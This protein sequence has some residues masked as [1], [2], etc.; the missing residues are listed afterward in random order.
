MTLPTLTKLLVSN[1][2]KF[3]LQE[4]QDIY[5]ISHEEKCGWYYCAKANHMVRPI[6][7]C[8]KT[9]SRAGIDLDNQYFEA[10]VGILYCET[11]ALVGKKC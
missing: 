11:Y 7:I 5:L 4:F 6:T 3:V 1:L 9:P 8:F 10:F 2:L